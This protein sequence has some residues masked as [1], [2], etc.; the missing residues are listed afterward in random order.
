MKKNL[1]LAGFLVIAS[2]AMADI[3]VGIDYGV[4]SNTDKATD[5]FSDSQKNKYNDFG[6]KIGGGRDGGWK[7][8]LRLSR[9]SYDKEIFDNTHKDLIEFGADTIKEFT[10]D[11]VK[12]FY[13]YVKLGFGYG[14]MNVDGYNKSSIA[15]FSFN[16]GVGVSYKAVE[17]FYIIAGAD[18]VGR[19]W[20][21]I[22]VGYYTLSVTGSGIKPYIGVN[23]AF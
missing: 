3:Y 2:S 10:L 1:L 9:I 17:H 20:K 13:P 11:S 7:G 6:I 5:D 23:Y 21:D 12:N 22:E 19:K 8:Q 14:S 4:N 15:E 18:Y 16:I